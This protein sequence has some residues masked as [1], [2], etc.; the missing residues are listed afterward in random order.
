[1]RQFGINWRRGFRM[2][3]RSLFLVGLALSLTLLVGKPLE[4]G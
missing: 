3:Y 1:M 4:G 2:R